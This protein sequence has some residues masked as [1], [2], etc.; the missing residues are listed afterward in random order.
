MIEDAARR[1]FGPLTQKY[2]TAAEGEAFLRTEFN[3][4]KARPKWSALNAEAGALMAE[5]DA[6]SPAAA[7]LAWGWKAQVDMFS[8]GDPDTN[9][10]AGTMWAEALSG[11]HATD[12]SLDMEVF[13][14]RASI[15]ARI[16]WS[17]EAVHES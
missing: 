14:R 17:Q 10:R 12:L 8:G 4:R 1:V 15:A 2:F 3:P 6:D 16:D 9:R 11:P 7:N 13:V 5:G